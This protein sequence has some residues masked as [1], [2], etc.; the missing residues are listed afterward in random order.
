MH[1]ALILRLLL[2]AAL[3][4]LVSAA[5]A[6]ARILSAP[7]ALAAAVIGTVAVAAGWSWGIILMVFF[8]LT[9]A[10]SAYGA[11]QKHELTRGVLAKGSRRD[12]VQVL[13]NGGV[14]AAAGIGWLV[15]GSPM[16]LAAGAGAI[17]AAAA[18]SWATEIGVALGG[19]PRSII[20]GKPLSRGTSGGV[21]LAGSLGSFAGA[22]TIAGIV[23]IIDWPPLAAFAA[24]FAGVLGMIMDSVLGATL[25]ARRHCPGCG[26]ETEQAVHHCGRVTQMIHGVR[27]MDNDIVNALATLSGAAIAG[28]IFI[29]SA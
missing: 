14:F 12:A 21:T 5:A 18:D 2:G 25:Q 10:L 8:A 15:T 20:S 17:A 27:W 24:F 29:V 1:D 7:G 26:T 11:E 13:S 19:E 6:R 3:A 23:L 4:A 22:A 16:W 9:S 28:I